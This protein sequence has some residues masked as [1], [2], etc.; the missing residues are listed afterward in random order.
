MEISMRPLKKII[1]Y[2]SICLCNAILWFVQA[3]GEG[4]PSNI[5]F[6]AKN[7][8]PVSDKFK[9]ITLAWNLRQKDSN[10]HDFT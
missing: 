5:V 9:L 6:A 8:F 4:N 7:K 1:F 10:C 2:S 3:L